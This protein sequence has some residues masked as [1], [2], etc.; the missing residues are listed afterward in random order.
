MNKRKFPKLW[1][2]PAVLS[3]VLGTAQA[4]ASNGHGSFTVDGHSS[5]FD[6]HGC[7][8]VKIPGKGGK[9]QMVGAHGEKTQVSVNSNDLSDKYRRV[10]QASIS[11][12]PSRSSYTA[13]YYLQDGNW[14]RRDGKAVDGPLLHLSVGHVE[15]NGDF[16]QIGNVGPTAP[17]SGHIE[18]DC[19]ALT[20]DKVAL[21]TD[22]GQPE[23]VGKPTGHATL[24]GH[25]ADFT[26]DMCAM[27]N[28]GD[29]GHI[30]NIRGEGEQ[31]GAMVQDMRTG[32]D[33]TRQNVQLAFKDGT[34][35]WSAHRVQK[36]GKWTTPDGKP[37][38]GPL[39]T[40]DGTHVEADGEFAL[41]GSKGKRAHGHLEADCPNMAD[42]SGH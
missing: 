28:I 40:I 5:D 21:L 38:S 19:P 34:G 2:L 1:L 4:A 33:E 15:V 24:D 25:G 10:Q 27:M 17:V 42:L 36:K 6:V 26:P 29:K 18:A 3:M 30:L 8:V 12:D 35:I 9:L 39:L 14:Q 32:P 7:V 31:L 22:E 16:E 13:D 41:G 37:A 11:L 20:A 23:A